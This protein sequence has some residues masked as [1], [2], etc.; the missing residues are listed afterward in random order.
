MT[1]YN[2]INYVETF[3][4][5]EM[6]ERDK[7]SYI[8]YR[9][10]RLKHSTWLKNRKDPTQLTIDTHDKFIIDNIKS[11]K[12][13]AF[14]SAGYY[15]DDLI[16]DLTVVEQWDIVQ[17]FYPACY[18]IKDRSLLK[19]YFGRQFDNFIVVNN[20][21]DMWVTPENLTLHCL[22]YS[23]TMNDGCLFFYSFRDTQINDWNRLTTDHYE[24]FYEWA[25]SLK[26]TCNLNL[27][28]HDIK[29]IDD[30]YD[31]INN[32]LENPDTT[33]GNLKFVFQYK[34]N[35]HTII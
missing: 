6:K 7:H 9:M 33:N 4:Q 19:S 16:P 13:C 2:N 3:D 14:G 35:S 11:G 8:R 10:G 18:I 20:R 25:I 32:Q 22:N 15:F 34:S 30:S 5:S 26:K 28:W 23:Y 24:Y 12:T 1:I 17:K 31:T 21:G 27:I 29:F